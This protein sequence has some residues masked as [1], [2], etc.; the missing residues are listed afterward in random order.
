MKKAEK[1]CVSVFDEFI[2]VEM[3]CEDFEKWCFGEVLYLKIF[4]E[5]CR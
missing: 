1:V 3:I 4:G 2:R 5:F